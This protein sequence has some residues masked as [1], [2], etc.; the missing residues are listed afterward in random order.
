MSRLDLLVGALLAL[1]VGIV[2]VFGGEPERESS[3]D[4]R[5]STLRSGP[6]GSKAVYDVLV[7]L[8]VSTERRRR[9]L[10]DLNRDPRHPPAVLAVLDPFLQLEAAELQQVARFVRAGGTAVSAGGGG[11]APRRAPSVAP[12]PAPPPGWPGVP[13]PVPPA[14][15][16]GPPGGGR[17]GGRG[18][19]GVSGGAG[20]RPPARRGWGP[21]QWGAPAARGQLPGAAARPGTRPPARSRLPAAA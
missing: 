3:L 4:T 12:P 20:G 19:P 10:F 5:P 2:L 16:G 17:F 1:T 8:G 13:G 14:G 9:P 21:R 18:G 15:G 11:G 7:R 6:D